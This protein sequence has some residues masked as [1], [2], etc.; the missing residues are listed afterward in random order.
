LAYEDLS[1]KEIVEI[2]KIEFQQ[3]TP[4]EHETEEFYLPH[5]GISEAVLQS[6]QNTGVGWRITLN[7]LA[8]VVLVA[9]ILVTRYI[10]QR[11]MAV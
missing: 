10:R 1:S 5:Y 3:P 8:I 11:S 2:R 7:A 6:F 9:A 4:L